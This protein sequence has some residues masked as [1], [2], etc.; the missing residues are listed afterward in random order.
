MTVIRI[1]FRDKE[2]SSGRNPDRIRG[3]VRAFALVRLFSC[4]FAIS[5]QR[6][7]ERFVRI[8]FVTCPLH[9]S[10]GI[11]AIVFIPRRGAVVDSPE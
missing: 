7:V 5:R 2:P 1:V 3:R 6:S 8:L 10:L 9:R 11:V 4:A